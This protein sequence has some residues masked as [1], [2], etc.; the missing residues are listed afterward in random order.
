MKTLL[1]AGVHFGH[2]TRRWHPKMKR[3]IFTQRNGIHIIDLQQTL[4][5]LIKACQ[6]VRDLV[7][8]GGTI[9]FVGTKKQA[10]EAIESEAQR[11]GMFW[12]NHRWL[13]GTLTNWTTLSSRIAYL[14]QLEARKARGELALLPK[15]EA[16]NL[17][18][19]IDRLNKEMGGI[20]DMLRLPNALF[21]VDPG[22]EK[23][24]IA[25]G[26]RLGTTIVALVDTDCNPE[27]VDYPIP[28]NDDAIRSAKLLTSHIAGAVLEGL[29]LRQ[30][31]LEGDSETIPEETE[32]TDEPSLS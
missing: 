12:V 32:M 11:C 21:V 31:R 6:F 4:D 2:Q 24:A 29:A 8:D 3:F 9:L 17:Q 1:E 10:Q 18:D 20:K 26:R 19:A 25:E 7:A 30:D 22:K 28:G 13:G 16:A 23:I 15:K 27:L 5:H 14:L